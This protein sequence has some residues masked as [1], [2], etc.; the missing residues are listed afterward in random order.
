MCPQ[1]RDV[2]S[3]H[4]MNMNNM[5]LL[6]PTLQNRLSHE[7]RVS[8]NLLSEFRVTTV[9]QQSFHVP[10]CMTAFVNKTTVSSFMYPF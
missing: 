9:A 10:L 1:F 7:T 3:P 8:G 5:T 4:D 2:D 6:F